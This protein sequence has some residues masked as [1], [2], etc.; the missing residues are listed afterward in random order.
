MRRD[1][2]GQTALR[3][4]YKVETGIGLNEGL[5]IGGG[6]PVEG[7]IRHDIPFMSIKMNVFLV[8]A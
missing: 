5:V 8:F 7:E 4:T 1:E 2:E 3:Y 6:E